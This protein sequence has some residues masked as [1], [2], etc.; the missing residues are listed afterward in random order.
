MRA[1]CG[2][3]V[4]KGRG[5]AY[6][7]CGRRAPGDRVGQQRIGPITR[8]IGSSVAPHLGHA[9]GS[10]PS[11]RRRSAATP[12]AGAGS[13]VEVRRRHSAILSFLPRLA[14]MP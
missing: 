3:A 11:M 12:G 9:A 10:R 7:V 6:R 2:E 4:R 5:S 13:G 14:R 1:A 8:T